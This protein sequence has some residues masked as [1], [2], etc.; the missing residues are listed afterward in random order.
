MARIRTIKPDFFHDECLA[1]LPLQHRMTFVGLWLYADREGRLEDRPKYLK[2]QLWPY[3]KCDIEKILNGL[4]GKFIQR[5]QVD[6]KHYI[7]II[8]FLKHQRPHHTEKDSVIPELTHGTLTV[9]SPLEDVELPDGREGKGKE[10]KGKEKTYAPK[11]DENLLKKLD[12]LMGEVQEHF[13]S[14]FNPYAFMTKSM[15]KQH[16]PVEVWIDLFTRMLRDKDKIQK[17]N[18][19][20]TQ[21]L[22]VEAG[23][24]EEALSIAEHE[25]LKKLDLGNLVGEMK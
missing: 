24:V 5:Y 14:K 1:E 11:T 9:S 12:P 18:A 2:S 6:I 17:P 4:N 10:R 8:N 23:N 19:W 25:E 20:A 3:D 16:R 22:R 13:G 21:V 15:N 7:Q